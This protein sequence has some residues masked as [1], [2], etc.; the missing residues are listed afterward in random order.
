MRKQKIPTLPTSD[1]SQYKTPSLNSPD[2]EREM[3]PASVKSDI[4][5]LEVLFKDKTKSG[6]KAFNSALKVCIENNPT[7]LL[8]EATEHG[9]KELVIAILKVNRDSIDSKTLQGLSVLHSAIAGVNNKDVIEILLQAEPTLVT[10]KDA[11]G[12][13]PLDYSTYYGSRVEILEILQTYTRDVK[14]RIPIESSKYNITPCNNWEEDM[15]E[16]L[17]KEMFIIG[18]TKHIINGDCI[19][20]L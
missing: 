16:Y 18:N 15:Q 6:I 17:K 3:K 11:S 12:L 19:E 8:H 14:D 2:S 20:N 7:A 5:E 9:K 13:T 10:K 1:L 4:E